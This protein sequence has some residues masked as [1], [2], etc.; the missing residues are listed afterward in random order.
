MLHVIDNLPTGLLERDA[1]ELHEILS[2]PTLIHLS[3]RR[4]EPL[5]V[6]ALLHG[7]EDTGWLA[8]RT[9]L[10]EYAGR[11]LPRAL[12]LFIG[13]VQAARYGQRFLNGQPDY[14]RIWCDTPID[15]HPLEWA[16]TRQVVEAMSRRAVFASVDIH[17]N[18]GYNPHYACVRRLDQRFFHLATLF[19]RTVVYF[20]KPDGVQAEPFSGLCPA[21]TVEC[22]QSGQL[23]GVEHALDYLK[24]CLNLAE[25]PNQRIATHDMDLFQTVAIVKV[26]RDTSFG[27][28]SDDVDIR[29]PDDLDRLNF[30]EL[31]VDT[32]LGWVRPGSHKRLEVWNA[33]GCEVSEQFLRID[34]GEIRTA[35]VVMPSMFTLNAGVI[36][37]DCLG[38]F[39]E[40]CKAP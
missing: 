31:P 8:A 40:S 3:G 7:N 5:F 27:F 11:E 10:R 33:R 21:V 30:H 25:I 13:N 26:P 6:S 17:N 16:M 2:G 24:A 38:Y 14:N 29:L 1:A 20:T 39:M 9:L 12:S 36:R 4:P 37:Q 35:S 23:H 34:N 32:V 18:S 15:E 22:G 19:S 28:N